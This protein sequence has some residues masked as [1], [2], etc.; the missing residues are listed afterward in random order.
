M[1]SLRRVAKFVDIQY[2]GQTRPQKVK[3]IFDISNI[4]FSRIRFFHEEFT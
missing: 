3:Y 4:I 2:I 1:Y